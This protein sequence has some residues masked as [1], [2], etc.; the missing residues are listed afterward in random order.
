MIV[1]TVIDAAIFILLIIAL[2]LVVHVI[3]PLLLLRVRTLRQPII[4]IADRQS[5]ISPLAAG[6]LCLIDKTQD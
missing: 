3:N 5:S 6:G 2:E 4:M 1:V